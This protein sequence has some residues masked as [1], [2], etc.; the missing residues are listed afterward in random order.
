MEL[1]T[2]VLNWRV[3]PAR[4]LAVAGGTVTGED[5]CLPDPLPPPMAVQLVSSARPS[6]MIDECR[7][8]PHRTLAILTISAFLSK[9]SRVRVLRSGRVSELDFVQT[10]LSGSAEKRHLARL[11]LAR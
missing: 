11:L 3:S 4:T 2:L 9:H 7:T 6:V 5:V 8:R 10:G 1:A